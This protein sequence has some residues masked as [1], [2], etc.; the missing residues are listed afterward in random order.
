M[1]AFDNLSEFLPAMTAGGPHP[2]TTT[3]RDTYLAS[4][5]TTVRDHVKFPQFLYD[6]VRNE[7]EVIIMSPPVDVD[8]TSLTGNAD[9]NELLRYV[10]QKF[11]NLVA[12]SN[13][14]GEVLLPPEPWGDTEITTGTLSPAMLRYA[15]STFLR[16]AIT[17]IM[18]KRDSEFDEKG[19][20]IYMHNDTSGS[21]FAALIGVAVQAHRDITPWDTRTERH[22]TISIAV[23]RFTLKIL[24]LLQ[25]SR[26]FDIGRRQREALRPIF[27]VNVR[28][29]DGMIHWPR[30]NALIRQIIT[31]MPYETIP[32]VP[33]T[34]EMTTS[35]GFEMVSV[36]LEEYYW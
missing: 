7:L 17:F 32:T 25:T 26:S 14:L 27:A 4:C 30:T 33:W 8:P 22:T 11:M 29:G 3:E 9:Y 18:K 1:F 19:F 2:M 20:T 23:A 12:M 36:F 13:E 6:L 31:V 24:S 28:D 10:S 21:A 34:A 15:F 5:L 16:S 35:E